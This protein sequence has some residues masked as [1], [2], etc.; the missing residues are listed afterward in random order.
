MICWLKLLDRQ[1]VR[2]EVDRMGAS[3][4]I[5]GIKPSVANFN[6]AALLNT[7]VN[8]ATGKTALSSTATK[9]FV[10]VAN[11]ALGIATDTL[12]SSISQ[13]LSKTIFSVRPYE[14][15]FKGLMK[16]EIRFGNHVRKLNIGD[17]DWENDVRYDLVDGESI[18]DQI[19]S[20]PAILQTNF[21]GQNVYSRHYTVYRDQLNIALSSEEEFQRFIT[22]IVQNCS[23][24]IEQCHESTARMTLANFIGGKVKGD[25]NNVIHLVTKYNEVAGTTF[26]TETI[27]QPS[28]FVPFI[29]WAF[30]YIGYLS[31]M[32]TERSQKFHINVT[33]K[34]ISRHTPQ[35]RQKL[36][37]FS[38][39]LKDMDA[40]VLSSV[41]NDN[42]LKFTDYEQV[43]FW[44]SIDTPDGISVKASYMK[45]DGTI[46]TDD[47]GTATG[48]IF[49]ALFDEEAVGIT[50]CG[51]WSSASRFNARGGYTNFWY[52]FN[53]RY[54][55]DF[56]EN[57]I[58]FLL[59]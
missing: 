23:D 53:D 1:A 52:H 49:G 2:M 48:N 45:P 30:G 31:G 25:V 43:N 14:A 7:I 40:S 33:G 47:T 29:K 46:A 6:S 3:T 37:L 55:N 24:M 27:R 4:S 36:Y 35:N 19:V 18:D 56:T 9:D 10:S 21:Y 16:D 15:K 28:N 8:Q 42:Y 13:T 32:L 50:T 12:L 20:N 58:V 38:E 41:Y 51:Q 57:G 59:D 54:Y 17:K 34:E 39:Y 26:T 11:T 44:Q 5:N 22:M